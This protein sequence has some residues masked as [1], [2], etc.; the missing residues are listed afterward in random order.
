[1]THHGHDAPRRP[2]P[3]WLGDP[4]RRVDGP[5]KVTGAALYTADR[6]MPGELV[7][8][9]LASPFP[10]AL[11]VNIDVSRAMAV[12][13]VHAVLTGRDIGPVR[14][15]RRLQDWPVLAIDRVR[16]AGEHVAAVAAETADAAEEAVGLISVDYEALEPVLDTRSALE[17]GAPV[18]HPDAA[19]YV[20][21][22]GTRPPVPHPNVQ[23][24]RLV[25]KGDPDLERIF[26]SVAHVFE[27]TFTVPP[28]HAGY[29][30]P[31]AT[32]VWID[33]AG[34]IH[35]VTPNKAP[36]N[37]RSQMSTALGI[38][39]HRLVIEV[40]HIGGDF[41]GKGL[42]ID[43]YAC[44]FLARETG[45]PI[46]A[47]TS[48]AD[49]LATINPRHAA[50]IE[51]R[52]AVDADGRF[53]AHDARILLD[54]GA[55]AAAKPLPHL[56]LAGA[57]NV[58]PAYAV[59][60]IRIE[61]TVAYTNHPPA[62]HVRSPG[63][64]QALFAGESHVDEIARALGRDPLEFR[65]LN[66]LREGDTSVEGEHIREPRSVQILE[67]IRREA[68]WDEPRR[69]GV[70]RGVAL[71]VR[72]IA[73]G[74]S[75]LKVRCSVDGRIRVMTGA[76]DQGG[77]VAT[78]VRRVLA[79]SLGVDE[80]SIEV[81]HG[82]TAEAPFDMGVGGSR[83]THLA[84]RA[85]EQAALQIIEALEER[86]EPRLAQHVSFGDGAF[87]ADDG[88]RLSFADAV[89]LAAPNGLELTA[90][91][92][93]AVH[94]DDEPA[95]FNFSGYCIEVEVDGETGVVKVRDALLVADIG[96]VINPVAHRGQLLGGFA[97]GI[98]AALTEEL[99]RVDGQVITANLGDMKLPAAHDVPPLRIVELS[100]NV[101]PGAF[102]A[103]MAGELS[104]TAVAPAIANAVRDAVGVRM[105]S[106]PIK[107]ELVLRGLREREAVEGG[108]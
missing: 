72:H 97:F 105:T 104:N 8:R 57:S 37:L 86:V 67:T 34:L 65:L 43:E 4:E 94:G 103:K 49:D 20:Y 12:S 26:G 69:P 100:T 96:T 21:L 48:A 99:V 11:I 101:G 58:L 13:G 82:S 84:S 92:E 25:T 51:L 53:L 45:R 89:A 7:A 44:F 90:T 61:I 50:S 42:T 24:R 78:V 91:F 75:G 47:L 52:T 2:A 10:H 102:G 68:K 60:N 6:H 29:L 54:G 85:A 64:V 22:A 93:A 3:S 38:P 1:M 23:G 41:G 40:P 66:A 15:G 108:P 79:A 9:F 95:D 30:E 74:K 46:R 16:F 27:H 39:A 70:G 33:E 87:T 62:G 77:G 17:P 28:L 88:R 14:M 106:L 32:L 35:V 56:T 81:T 71:A 18:L 80:E 76:P 59:P 63:E 98:G 55:Y 73:G 31:H 107:P 36:F 5:E 83:A 19:E